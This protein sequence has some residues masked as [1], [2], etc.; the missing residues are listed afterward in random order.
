VIRR[1]LAARRRL[2][3]CA[4]DVVHEFADPGQAST[5]FSM[6]VNLLVIAIGN[7]RL[8]AGVFVDGS[9]TEVRHFP[10]DD[11]AD[12]DARLSELWKLV[13]DLE[14][15]EVAGCSV[16]PVMNKSIQQSVDRICGQP[17]QWIGEQIDLP[18]AV[19]TRE[20]AKTGI[21]RVL[22][23]AAAHEQ[24]EKACVVVDA[25]TAVTINLCNDAGAMVGGSILPGVRLMLGALHDNTAQLP[26]LSFEMPDG[27][28]GVDTASSI[29][30]GITDAIRGAVQFAAERWAESCGTWPEVIATGG[31]AHALFDGWEVVHAISPDLLLY[32]VALAY[33]QHHIRHGT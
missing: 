11:L 26:A 14:N 6:Q 9:L 27:P 15:S 1:S 31:D 21:D 13:A 30:H 20:P 5:G 2:L 33:T 12:L 19:Q 7:S 18:I 22:V 25:G 24:L 8:H 10:H 16:V 4:S 32:G 28:H 17:I 23:V 29:R 3:Y